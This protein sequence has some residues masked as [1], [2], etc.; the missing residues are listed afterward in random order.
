[1]FKNL[2]KKLIEEV[3]WRIL[4]NNKTVELK[5]NKDY[6]IHKMKSTK[7]INN[8]IAFLILWSYYNFFADFVKN[9]M[10]LQTIYNHRGQLTIGFLTIYRKSALF[11][12]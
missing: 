10:C 6:N 11:K 7:A 4:I 5:Y 2:Q 3:E 8:T 12:C 9:W 1:M